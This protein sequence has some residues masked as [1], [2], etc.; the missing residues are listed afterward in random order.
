MEGI[1]ATFAKCKKE[2]RTALVTYITCGYPST[3]ETPDIM[4]G[5]QAG[6]AGKH[7]CNERRRCEYGAN[8]CG[9]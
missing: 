3:D 1:K 7:R 2:N 8:I 6:G 5:L 4:L 9:C